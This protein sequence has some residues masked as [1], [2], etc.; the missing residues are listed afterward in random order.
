MTIHEFAKS[1]KELFWYIK[2]PEDLSVESI[3]EHILNYGDWDDV[4][5]LIEILGCRNVGRIFSKQ[6]KKKR[7]NYDEKIKHYF[8]LYFKLYA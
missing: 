8:K 4:Q 1:R 5:K 6:I 7:T 2:K 3:V